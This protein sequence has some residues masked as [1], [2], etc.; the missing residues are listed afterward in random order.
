MYADNWKKCS[1]TKWRKKGREGKRKG[2]RKGGKE[3]RKQNFLLE[4][5]AL[6]VCPAEQQVLVEQALLLVFLLPFAPF[7]RRVFS[8]AS[9]DAGL[10]PS[11]W[12]WATQ[13]LLSLHL[14]TVRVPSFVHG[15]PCFCLSSFSSLLLLLLHW[16]LSGAPCAWRLASALSRSYTLRSSHCV[17]Q[18]SLESLI[19]QRLPLKCQ[20]VGCTPPAAALFPFSVSLTLLCS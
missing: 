7:F 3:G 18:A 1:R 6:R 8:W 20:D 13:A 12:S 5:T 4:Q 11:F 9:S 10:S 16:E 2:E 17:A 15:A 19:L 14:S